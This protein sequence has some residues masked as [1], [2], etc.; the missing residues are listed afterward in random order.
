MEDKAADETAGVVAVV[1]TD[2]S[3]EE[4]GAGLFQRVG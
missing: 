3:G 1:A 4:A 2:R